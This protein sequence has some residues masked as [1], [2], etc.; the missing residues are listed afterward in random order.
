M[1]QISPA[2]LLMPA[3]LLERDRAEIDVVDLED[4]DVIRELAD[5]YRVSAQALTFRLNYLGYIRL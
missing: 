5:R 4:E 1:R 2:E 3:H